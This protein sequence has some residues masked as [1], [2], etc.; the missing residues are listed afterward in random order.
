MADVVKARMVIPF[1]F[2]EADFLSDKFEEGL[3]VR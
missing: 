2:E 3:V 1:R